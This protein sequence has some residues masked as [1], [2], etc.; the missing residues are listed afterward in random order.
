M[1]TMRPFRQWAA[2]GLATARRGGGFTTVELLVVIAIVAILVVVG[3]P[4][5]STFMNNSRL[6]ATSSQLLNEL[7]LA[8]SEA[9]K[10]NMR[11][12][13]CVRN[14]AGTDCGSGT[15]WA[16]GWLV[17]YDNETDSTGNGI[18]DGKCDVAPVDGS[19]PNPMVLQ[20]ALA[21]S[22]TLT[23]SASTIR[24]NPNGSQG[25]SPGGTAATL[26]VGLT[27]ATST[28]T[29]TVAVTGNISKQ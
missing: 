13:V 22:I 29:V 20:P 19:N 15:N 18:A 5:F 3:A 6:S 16:A 23:G 25:T 12:L 28:R 27:S 1:T 4:S 8:R 26:L 9:I 24:F 14:A 2:T 10:R 17:C 11:V 21:S 7:N